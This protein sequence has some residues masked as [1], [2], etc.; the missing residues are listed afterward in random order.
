[1][2]ILINRFNFMYFEVVMKKDE[3][4]SQS[5]FIQGERL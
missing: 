4:R 1:M 3:Y 2:F 5:E